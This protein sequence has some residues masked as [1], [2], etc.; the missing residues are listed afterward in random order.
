MNEIKTSGTW[1][2]AAI[3][4]VFS[5]W[6]ILYKYGGE[7]KDREGCG[8]LKNPLTILI[9]PKKLLNCLDALYGE[10]VWTYAS[11]I[12]QNLNLDAIIGGDE[13]SSDVHLCNFGVDWETSVQTQKPV[14]C[15][16]SVNILDIIREPN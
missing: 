1:P 11:I 7:K 9:G 10:T 3:K 4:D 12:R 14:L 16:D 13:A 2:N 6:E 5:A 8:L 15:I